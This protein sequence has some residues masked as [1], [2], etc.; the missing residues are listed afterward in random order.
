MHETCSLHKIIYVPRTCCDTCDKF[1]RQMC[2]RNHNIRVCMGFEWLHSV[3]E[4][5]NPNWLKRNANSEWRATYVAGQAKAS[6]MHAPCCLVCLL[7]YRRAVFC[8]RLH[9]CVSLT[10]PASNRIGAPCLSPARPGATSRNLLERHAVRILIDRDGA[11]AGARER[12]DQGHDGRVG[13]LHGRLARR[14]V[15]DGG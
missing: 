2:V 9:A 7:L 6:V 5:W 1:K 3:A 14:E 15:A 12:Q 13:A 10:A 4:T 11:C 8:P